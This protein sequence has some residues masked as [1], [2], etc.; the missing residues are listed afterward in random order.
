MKLIVDTHLDLAWN[1][2][3]WDRDLTRPLAEINQREAGMVG[4]VRAAAT[5]SLPEMR[6]AGVAVCLATVMARVKPEVRPPEGQKRT[7]IDYPNHAIACAVAQGQLAYYR[8]LE[9]QGQLCFL[10][11]SDELDAHWRQWQERP[12]DP[13]ELPIGIIL[14]MEGA[15]P[16]VAPAQAEA[17]FA[18]GLRSASLAHY[19]QGRYA[20]GTGGSGP[21]TADGVELLR[22]FER[23]GV[24]LDVTHLAEPGFSQ[25]LDLFAGP[26]MASH[27]NCRALVPGDRQ[28]SDEQIRR[29]I[30]REA[31]IGV[32]LDAW[33]LHPGWEI[34]KTSPEVVGLDAVADHVDHICQL[35]GNCLH[36]GIGSDLD[37]GYGTEQ[38]PRDL[39]TIADLQKLA[40]LLAA[41]GYPDDHVDA[42]FHGNWLHFFRRHLGS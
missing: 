40:D 37:G 4:P 28:F 19:G 27:N 3:G 11:T 16:I 39:K 2:L 12:D 35:A 5:T 7:S 41:R 26:V 38:T 25:A 13:A 18:D 30:E 34:G 8:L 31:V 14:A 22:E 10:R 23:L 9:Q 33:M 36:A 24:I 6:R 15:D 42:L 32:A 17:W 20:M 29:L 1:A 21:V